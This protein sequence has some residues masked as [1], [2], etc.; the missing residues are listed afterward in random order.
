GGA[1]RFEIGQGPRNWGHAE[2]YRRLPSAGLFETSGKPAF[3]LAGRALQRPPAPFTAE[4]K[5]VAP[6]CP[7]IS[8]AKLKDA[9]AALRR[10][11]FDA[12]LSLGEA[13]RCSTDW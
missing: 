13:L 8:S 4:E 11:Y 3:V 5:V 7:E 12:V 2:G 10:D 9:I 1:D 6:P